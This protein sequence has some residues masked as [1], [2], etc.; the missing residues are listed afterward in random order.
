MKRVVKRIAEASEEKKVILGEF[1]IDVKDELR[2]KSE[3]QVEGTE[4]M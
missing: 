2:G 1:G 4:E 3:G